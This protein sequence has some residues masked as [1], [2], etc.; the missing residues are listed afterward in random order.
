LRKQTLR[1][2]KRLMIIDDIT[3]TTDVTLDEA[4][5]DAVTDA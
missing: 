3:D 2:Y 1:L 5:V 4:A